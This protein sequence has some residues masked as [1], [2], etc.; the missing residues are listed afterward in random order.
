MAESKLNADT[1]QQAKEATTDKDVKLATQ[2]CPESVKWLWDAPHD[3]DRM[4]FVNLPAAW[5]PPNNGRLI[6]LKG[7]I[8]PRKAGEQI[9]FDVLADP[10]NEPDA[11]LATLAT[12]TATTDAKGEAKVKLTLPVYGG[13]RFTVG[14]KTSSMA[15]P[16]RTGQI[17]VWRKVFYQKTN[18]AAPPPPPV[19]SLDAPADMI[20]ALQ[21]AFEPVFFKIEP[22]VKSEDTT[23]YKAHLTASERGT[24][25]T[26]LRANARDARSP[27]KMNIVMVD[28]A[29]IVAEQ[30]WVSA[31]NSATVTTPEFV[32]WVHE[33]TVIRAEYQT[34]TTPAPDGTWAALTNVNEKPNATNSSLVAVEATIPHYTTGSTVQVRIKYRYQRGNAGGWGGTTGTLFMCIGRQRRAHAASPTGAELQ[35]ALT[36]EIGHALGLV[37]KN[38]AWHDPDPRDAPYN[39][40][41]C[42]YKDTA[43]PPQP[44]CVMWYMLGGAGARLR[45]CASNRPD[46]CSHFLF[47]TDYSTLRWI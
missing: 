39:P 46:D 24:L 43:T 15:A 4:Q 31:A 41:H 12:T 10:A 6:E 16:V 47:R 17:T 25:E 14:G 19:L 18:M 7:H 38:A 27:F 11:P 32:K 23:P 34:S 20:S 5:D 9:T 21:G 2:P 37:P 44:R 42:T 28:T 29:D 45:F 40:V 13:A 30:E 36:H 33:P 35:Q 22:G 8:E 26:T 3:T 1:K